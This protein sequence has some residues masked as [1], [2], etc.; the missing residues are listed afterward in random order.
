[1]DDRIKVALYL[2]LGKSHKVVEDSKKMSHEEA[3][4]FVRS[5]SLKPSVPIPTDDDGKGA[6]AETKYC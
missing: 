2:Q 5:L 6:L 1:M 3:L 4:K